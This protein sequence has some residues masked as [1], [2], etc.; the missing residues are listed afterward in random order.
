MSPRGA[1]PED[2]ETKDLNG[3][4]REVL[5]KQEIQDALMRYCR[6]ID[7]CD[8]VG[9]PPVGHGDATFIDRAHR[10]V[11]SKDDISCA[12]LDL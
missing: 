6:G 1:T 11:R 4:L 7:R 2:G 10:G 8:E 5:D 12:V 3:R 9:P